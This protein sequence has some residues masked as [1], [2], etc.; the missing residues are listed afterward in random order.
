MKHKESDN[1]QFTSSQLNVIEQALNQ[2]KDISTTGSYYYKLWGAILFIYFLLNYVIDS[3]FISNNNQI[4]INI[5]VLIFPFGGYLS[6]KKKL[7]DQQKETAQSKMERIYFFGFIS[8]SIGYAI[9]FVVSIWQQ[10]S[11]FLKIYP[12]LIGI[13]VFNIGGIIRHKPSVFLGLIGCCCAF[14]SLTTEGANLYL[15]AA[16]VSIISIFL[17]GILMKD[18][19]I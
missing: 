16:I 4:L 5:S 19:K 10:S 14:F 2:A 9:L 18:G 8:F 17:P 12:L 13:T 1:N 7:F 3:N 11:I 15:I 6:Y